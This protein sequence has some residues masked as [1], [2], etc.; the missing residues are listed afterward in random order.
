MGGNV[1][2]NW[3]DRST[4]RLNTLETTRLA[5]LGDVAE[6]SLGSVS[7]FFCHQTPLLPH[8]KRDPGVAIA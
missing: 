1:V 6:P 8:T 2:G 7:L 4:K 3:K 5:K